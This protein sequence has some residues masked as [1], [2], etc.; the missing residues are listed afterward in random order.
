VLLFATLALRSSFLFALTAPGGSQSFFILGIHMDTVEK[1]WEWFSLTSKED[2]DVDLMNSSQ[3]PE[4]ILV[5][6]FLTPRLLNIESVART[7]K[8]LW[9]TRKN[10]T[11]QDLG[12]N[13]VA[14]VFDDAMDLERVLISEPWSFHKF[15]VVFNWLTGDTPISDLTFT[16]SSFWVQL[17]NLP[18]RKM[19]PDVAEIIG[20]TIGIVE[21]VA[22]NDDEKGVRIVYVFMSVWILLL[23]CAVVKK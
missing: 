3:R 16:H 20:R 22:D 12:S 7:F 10:Y 4:H 15:L 17:H 1:L 18:V 5:A 23:H 21:K 19:M 13:R 6:K 11:V 8:L 2:P 9:K 14:F